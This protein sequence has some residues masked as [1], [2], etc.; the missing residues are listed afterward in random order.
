MLVPGGAPPGP[1]G[2]QRAACAQCAGRAIE[3]EERILAL[4]SEDARLTPA[5]LADMVDSTEEEVAAAI[6][7]FEKNK[8]ILAYKAMIDWEKT[9]KELITALIEVK[10]SPEK[11]MGFDQ[12]ARDIYSH[13]QVESV[14]LMSGAFDLTVIING[15]SMSDIARFVFDQ[16]APMEHVQ[17]TSTHFILKKYKEQGVNYDPQQF[18]EREVLI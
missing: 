7:A 2:L 9:D 11:A 17:S 6:R 1:W 16:L 3:K 10:I 12:I 14:Y 15:R 18:D 4:L 8:T 5:Q 13:R